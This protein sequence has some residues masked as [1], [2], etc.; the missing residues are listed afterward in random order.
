MW[1]RS[2]HRNI[3]AAEYKE[4]NLSDEKKRSLSAELCSLQ[5][6]VGMRTAEV[7]GLRENLA[8]SEQQLEDTA[9]TRNSLKKA[10]ARIEDLKLK[11]TEK[12]EPISMNVKELQ[13]WIRNN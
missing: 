4:E 7:R 8:T 6:V 5:L 11:K 1:V 10:H 13:W 9:V 3:L 2:C 12:W